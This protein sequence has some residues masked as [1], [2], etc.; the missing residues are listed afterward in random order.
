MRRR[1]AALAVAALPFTFIAASCDDDGDGNVDNPDLNPGDGTGVDLDPGAGSG[2]P[3][4]A[5][6]DG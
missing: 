2:V 3:G 5:L 6:D 1:V 4:T